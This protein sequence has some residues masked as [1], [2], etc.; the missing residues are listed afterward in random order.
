MSKLGNTHEKPRRFQFKFPL[1]TPEEIEIFLAV[2]WGVK[3]PKRKI[4][5]DHCS[6]WEAFCSAYFA[7]D[8][9]TE[10]WI[11]SRGFAGKTFTLGVLANLEALSYGADIVVLGG[12]EDQ[13]VNVISASNHLWR[14]RRAPRN[15]LLNRNDPSKVT[16][17]TNGATIHA[18]PSSSTAARG[19]HP[20][21]LRF[22]EVD[23][24]KL[25][26]IDAAF[27]QPMSRHGYR[28][29]LVLS[30]PHHYPAGS[31]PALLARAREKGWMIRRW[32]WRECLSTNGGWLN[33]IDV[34]TK[35]RDVTAL[36]WD[37]EYELQEPS[38][39]DRAIVPSKVKAM[40]DASLGVFVGTAGEDLIF[41]PPYAHA[42]YAH[43]ID[44]AKKKDWTIIVTFRTDVKPW[45]MVAWGRHG[46]M[47]WPEI[48]RRADKR[49]E[50]YPGPACHDSTG[51]GT[52]IDDYR[53]Q[54][55]IPVMMVGRDRA[56]LFSEYI[57][58]VEDG[59]DAECQGAFSAPLIRYAYEE[60]LYCSRDS[61][62]GS[63]H[64]P[65]SMVANAMARR[66]GMSG[67]F[68]GG[69]E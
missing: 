18:I 28:T 67:R 52:V 38:S 12:S 29:H 41:E 23:E 50:R 64:P 62:Y 10:M 58:D 56:N 61:L 21:R 2:A 14:F 68:S 59:D 54:P 39:D 6:P 24:I 34:E 8:Y 15:M 16:K 32:C 48:V 44:W 20:L 43:G 26:I 1:Q 51:I 17:F 9:S 47:P 40:F 66:A 3:I 31:V 42:T 27:G 5:A 11:G 55:M 7:Q 65:D 30:S 22:D 33:P 49:V 37:T 25:P 46:R 19:P 45:R 57:A 13:S 60:H 36:M 63:G 69:I 35:R 4:C 53:S